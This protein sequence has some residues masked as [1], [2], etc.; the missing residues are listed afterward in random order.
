M[1][2]REREKE[3]EFERALRET[4]PLPTMAI[5][6]GYEDRQGEPKF[7]ASNMQ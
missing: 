6:S 3:H 1:M 2:A 5:G 4:S 7:T